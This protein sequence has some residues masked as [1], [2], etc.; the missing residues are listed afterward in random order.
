MVND[1]RIFGGTFET[2]TG[3]LWVD[4]KTNLPVLLELETVADKGSMHTKMVFD[5]FK[6]DVQLD[7]SVFEPNIPADYTLIAEVQTSDVKDEGKAIEGLRIFAEMTNGK[8][9]LSL[10]KI[11]IMKEFGKVAKKSIDIPDANRGPNS[12]LTPQEIERK[13]K[14]FM[15]KMSTVQALPGFYAQLVK[16]NK[17]PVY[18]GDKITANDVDAVLMRWKISDNEYRPIFG[19]LTSENISAKRLVELESQSLK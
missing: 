16:E 8:Y 15:E 5:N 10:S 17:D 14:E 12:K 3:Y 18:Y 4:V 7:P 9:T 11:S 6:W 1:P 13:Q 19:D 2:F